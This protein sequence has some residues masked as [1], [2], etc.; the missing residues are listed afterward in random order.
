MSFAV[1]ASL[2]APLAHVVPRLCV[3]TSSN[4]CRSHGALAHRMEGPALCPFQAYILTTGSLESIARDSNGFSE[5]FWID[6]LQA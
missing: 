6:V 1:V 2:D 3:P 4:H 5:I